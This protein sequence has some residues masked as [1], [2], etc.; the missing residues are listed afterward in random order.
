[1]SPSWNQIEQAVNTVLSQCP[2]EAETD[3]PSKKRFVELV[4]AQ[5]F[6]Q[7]GGPPQLER[8][9]FAV[10][11]ER[12]H[13]RLFNAL[14]ANNLTVNDQGRVIALVVGPAGEDFPSWLEARLAELGWRDALTHLQEALRTF[15][16]GQWAASNGQIRPFLEEVFNQIHARRHAGCDATGGTARQHLADLGF[17]E[18]PYENDLLARMFAY[19]GTAG[20]H[21]GASD[22]EEAAYHQALGLATAAFFLRRFGT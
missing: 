13:S 3:L 22:P 16:D 14:R 21:A 10:E 6:V 4:I 19:L 1:M 12:Q 15:A 11:L 20:S 7:P 17:I 2:D 8:P 9:G 5:I 18:T